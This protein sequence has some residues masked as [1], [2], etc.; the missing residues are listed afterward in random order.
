M[1]LWASGF[2]S[3]LPHHPAVDSPPFAMTEQ[4]TISQ[5]P[6]DPDELRSPAE[7][8]DAAREAMGGIELDPA[9]CAVAN[10]VVRAER[11]YAKDDLGQTRDWRA[12]SVWL[13]PPRSSPTFDQFIWRMA[14]DY[15]AG[16]FRQGIAL[17]DSSTESD[18]FQTLGASAD[19]IIFPPKRARLWRADGDGGESKSAAPVGHAL[20]YFGDRPDRFLD[21]M[22]K[23]VGGLGYGAS[24][25]SNAQRR[26]PPPT[27]ARRVRESGSGDGATSFAERWR[28]K[29]SPAERDDDPRYRALARKYLR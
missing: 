24:P 9:S 8:V 17:V 2:E 18:W 16:V 4:A 1:C 15:E 25:T 29:F 21:I 10:G 22:R 20:I 5:H 23:R 19:A 28:G 6:A 12:D 27:A 7:Y 3:R 13:S 26:P 11:Y 14:A